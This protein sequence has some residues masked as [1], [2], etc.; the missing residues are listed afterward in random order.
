MGRIG[1]DA[2]VFFRTQYH[3]DCADSFDPVQ[4]LAC[5]WAVE[6]GR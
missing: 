4:Q 2:V 5:G 6:L 1:H 3:W